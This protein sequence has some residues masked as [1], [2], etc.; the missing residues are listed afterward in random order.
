MNTTSQ[1]DRGASPE[2]RRSR[3]RSRSSSVDSVDSM[4]SWATRSRSRSPSPLAGDPAGYGGGG[5]RQPFE[6][7]QSED[8]SVWGDSSVASGDTAAMP[9]P[10]RT[11]GREKQRRQRG[12]Q[13]TDGPERRWIPF[14]HILCCQCGEARPY[15]EYTPRQVLQATRGWQRKNKKCPVACEL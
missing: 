9:P 15:A 7:D 2:P 12:G 8:S 13:S 5:G 11:A 6:R 4:D 3:S 10:R 1:V 14:E